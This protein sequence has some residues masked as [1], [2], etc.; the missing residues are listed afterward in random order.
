MEKP[1]A[2]NW[3][4]GSPTLF[5]TCARISFA[6]SLCL[7]S[8]SVYTTSLAPALSM[9]NPAMNLLLLNLWFK[10]LISIQGNYCVL[11]EAQEATSYT[12]HRGLF[13]FYNYQTLSLASP[14][15]PDTDPRGL[16]VCGDSLTTPICQVTDLPLKTPSLPL[17]A[18]SPSTLHLGVSPR[19][20]GRSV[21]NGSETN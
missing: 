9:H 21:S 8:C 6:C 2:I 7:A 17:P 11:R 5:P 15:F 3:Q 20:W 1:E 13:I 10:Y 19:G 12:S 18:Q 4:P 16:K 14:S